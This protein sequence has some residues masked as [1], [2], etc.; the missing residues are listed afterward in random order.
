MKYMNVIIPALPNLIAM[1]QDHHAKV[2]EAIAWVMSKIC[3]HHADVI[4]SQ[5]SLPTLMPIFLQSIKDKPRI[6]N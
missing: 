4:A 5:Q 1:F 2:R 3:E 6:S